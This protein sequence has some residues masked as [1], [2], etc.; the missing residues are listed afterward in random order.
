MAHTYFLDSEDVLKCRILNLKGEETHIGVQFECSS[1]KEDSKRSTRNQGSTTAQNEDKAKKTKGPTELEMHRNNIRIILDSS[2]AT[3]IRA[4]G[5]IGYQCC[6]CPEQY[7]N[8]A[9]LKTH[10]IQGHDTKTKR[11]FMRGKTMAEYFVKL[12]ITAMRCELCNS[13]VDSLELLTSHLIDKHG[14]KMY[15]D[16][17]SHILPFKFGDETLR[18]VFCPNDFNTFKVLQEH[19][20]VHFRNYIC[21]TCD[22]GFVTR[23]MRRNHKKTHETG[24]FICSFC[25]KVYD[26]ALKQRAHEKQ[27]HRLPKLNLCAY[28]NERFRDFRQKVKHLKDVH[29]VQRESPKCKAC[30]RTFET[31]AA[32]RL[33]IKRDHLIQRPHKCSQCDMSFYAKAQ[34]KNHFVIHSERRQCCQNKNQTT[35]AKTKINIEVEDVEPTKSKNVFSNST[36]DKRK[37]GSELVLEIRNKPVPSRKGHYMKKEIRHHKENL[38]IILRCSD[39][40]LIRSRGNL[41]YTCYFCD[42]SCREASSL[43]QHTRD[44]HTYKDK[45]F[46][47]GNNSNYFVKLDITALHCKLCGQSIDQLEQLSEHLMKIHE[48]PLH[49][50]TKSLMIPFKFETEELKCAVC[51]QEFNN[52]H[53]LLDHMR[54]HYRNFICDVCDEGYLSYNSM[55][56]HQLGHNVGEYTCKECNKLFSSTLKLKNHTRVVHLGIKR[57]KCGYC[58]EKFA[59]LN[60]KLDHLEKV[61]GIKKPEFKCTVCNKKFSCS[62]SLRNHKRGFHLMEKDQT[63]PD[64][65]L[66]FFQK[67][68]LKHH[69]TIH[70]GLRAFKCAVCSKAF[71][72]RSTL[73]EHMRI[74][75]NDRRFKCEH[76]NMAFVQKCSWKGHMRSKHEEDVT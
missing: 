4:H 68:T 20:N 45:P 76:C 2:N 32:L 62:K 72:R 52:F 28:C 39:A 57:N 40:T 64:C 14:K 75:N 29:G 10:T 58:G 71:S 25:P 36:E 63:C 55:K 17:E 11:A 23:N 44:N 27:V 15:T 56:T 26:T 46:I 41:G 21:E 48:E 24:S 5:G 65:G 19:M 13:N 16:I 70:T 60:W 67:H 31:M 35:K 30:E 61:H 1:K 69:M 73:R 51:S 66:K 38:N 22:S 33:H 49:T 74:H 7:P 37:N 8:P 54:K 50:L 53:S 59:E 3:P 34:L 9:D 43:K 6:F 47:K 18:C 12:D 42:T